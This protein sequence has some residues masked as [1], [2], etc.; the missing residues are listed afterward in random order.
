MCNK[1]QG[2]VKVYDYFQQPEC[3]AAWAL[4]NGSASCCGPSLISC[5]M[6]GRDHA[7]RPPK[8]I[9]SL[10]SNN[11]CPLMEGRRNCRWSSSLSSKQ[12]ERTRH[13]IYSKLGLQDVGGLGPLRLDLWYTYHRN[14]HRTNFFC[15]TE[16]STLQTTRS[17]IRK[18]PP[19]DNND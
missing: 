5:L 12:G 7:R 10:H 15:G 14:E 16:S 4:M 1:Q 13:Q 6:D 2:G 11:G 9:A 18:R 3:R 19:P 17:K 8:L